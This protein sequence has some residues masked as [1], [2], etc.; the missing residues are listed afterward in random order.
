VLVVSA[1]VTTGATPEPIVLPLSS[2][3]PPDP[4]VLDPSNTGRSGAIVRDPIGSLHAATTSAITA[5]E[6]MRVRLM[7]ILP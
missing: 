3:A 6:R 2:G 5:A 4:T 7:G 1:E